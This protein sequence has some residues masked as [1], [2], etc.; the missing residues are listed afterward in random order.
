VL[1]LTGGPPA[2]EAP[3]AGEEAADLSAEKIRR[4]VDQHVAIIDCAVGLHPRKNFAANGDALLNDPA[5]LRGGDGFF[6]DGVPLG[7]AGFP[8][9]RDAAPPVFVTGFQHQVLSLA[10]DEIEEFDGHALMRS[11]CV[12]HDTC[13]GNVIADE[14]TFV[15]GKKSVVTLVSEHREERLD[16]RDFA[17]EVVG[18]AG[19]V[20]SDRIDQWFAFSGTGHD[21]VDEHAAIDEVNFFAVGEQRFAVE[22]DIAR[23]GEFNGHAHF[24]KPRCSTLSHG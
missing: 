23:V 10:T 24:F 8:A 18:H 22:L 12:G 19:G 6:D 3:E 15:E 7:L 5:A 21:V 16:M 20:C 11:A 2:P 13:P 4:E 14:F 9:E 1:T 17:A